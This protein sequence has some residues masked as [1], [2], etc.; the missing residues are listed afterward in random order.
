ML[1]LIHTDLAAFAD[2]L[3]R[4]RSDY[5][6]LKASL[7]FPSGTGTEETLALDEFR[8][9]ESGRNLGVEDS[10]ALVSHLC[11]LLQVYRGWG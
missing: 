10:H 11:S 5:A 7:S 1:R 3:D 9:E 2:A 8:P 6:S 4:R